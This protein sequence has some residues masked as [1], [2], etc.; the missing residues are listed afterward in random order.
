[1]VR[2]WDWL[3]ILMLALVVAGCAVFVPGSIKRSESIDHAVVVSTL[4]DIQAGVLEYRAAYDVLKALEPN[5]RER[6]DWM[7]M[8]KEEE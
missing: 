4:R 3:V 2:R 8:R 6:V 1:M 7:Y 5:M